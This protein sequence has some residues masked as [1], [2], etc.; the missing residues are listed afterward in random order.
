[1]AS[2]HGKSKLDLKQVFDFVG[3]Q[4]NLKE[5]KVRPTLDGLA[6][7]DSKS[8][9]IINWTDLSGPATDIPHKTVD[10]NRK[11]GSPRS[12]PYVAHTVAPQKQLEGPRITRKGDTSSQVAPPSSKLVAGGKQCAPG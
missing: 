8:Q 9:R 3:Y 7:T 1:M 4:F 2:K 10:S 11:K 12:T 5:G 6:D